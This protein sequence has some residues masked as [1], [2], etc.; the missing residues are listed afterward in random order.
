MP[1]RACAACRRHRRG[2]GEPIARIASAGFIP[3]LSALGD[4][5]IARFV[6]GRR[7]CEADAPERLSYVSAA[8]S[9]KLWRAVLLRALKST[10]RDNAFASQR[11]RSLGEQAAR[12]AA[13]TAGGR[14]AAPAT[15]FSVFGVAT[16]SDNMTTN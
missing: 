8:R 3:K 5:G 4:W 1:K 14:E 13:P 6:I 11:R 12:T 16:A 15:D 10:T 9:H 2:K 7:H